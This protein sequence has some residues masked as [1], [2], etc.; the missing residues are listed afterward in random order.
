MTLPF[1]CR[2]I[3][4]IV[5]KVKRMR[6]EPENLS[7]RE[8]ESE[9][10]IEKYQVKEAL[11]L[12]CELEKENMRVSGGLNDAGIKIFTR[13]GR[14]LYVLGENRSAVAQ[15]EKNLCLLEA[16]HCQDNW[17]NIQ[18]HINLGLYYIA[19]NDKSR[20]VHY[21]TKGIF[22]MLVTFGETSPDLLTSL[23]NLARIHHLSK[24]YKEAIKC[25]RVAMKFIQQVHGRFHV[26]MSLCYISLATIYYEM[27]DLKSAIEYQ[28][29]N[30]AIL[31]KVGVAN[32]DFS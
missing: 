30:V 10:L 8:R 28:T 6:V 17:L 32:A 22:L 1:N 27:A 4:D 18:S 16:L 24:D 20:V 19:A 12:D 11:R 25:Y 9:K 14:I 7:E 3:V 13:M 2:N 26:K 29:E 15:E 23:A 31:N 5:P 21:I